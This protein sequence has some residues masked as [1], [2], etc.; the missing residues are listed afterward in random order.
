MISTFLFFYKTKNKLC[1]VYGY[2]TLWVFALLY[3]QRQHGKRSFYI[4]G[5]V[6]L[7][8]LYPKASFKNN[9]SQK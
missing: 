4:T 8:N 5:V 2:K 7:L 6:D 3:N 1:Y 9:F